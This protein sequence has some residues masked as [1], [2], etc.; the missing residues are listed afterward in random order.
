[1]CIFKGKQ[2][3]AL[4]FLVTYFVSVL[5]ASCLVTHAWRILSV[6]DD[7]QTQVR[8]DLGHGKLLQGSIEC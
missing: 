4:S 1:M 2:G 6:K 8:Q 3:L 7:L 5:S